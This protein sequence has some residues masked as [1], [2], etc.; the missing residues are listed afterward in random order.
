M[1]K[2][3]PLTALNKRALELLKKYEPARYNEYVR[4][5]RE[6][7][8]QSRVRQQ[9]LYHYKSVKYTKNLLVDLSRSLNIQEPVLGSNSNQLISDKIETYMVKGMPRE[10]IINAYQSEVQGFK[11]I[12]AEMRR[13]GKVGELK[14]SKYVYNILGNSMF[15]K[16]SS[17]FD[18]A[19]SSNRPF[20]TFE[21]AWSWLVNIYLG[22]TKTK[23]AITD[24]LKFNKLS[25]EDWTSTISKLKEEL[26]ARWETI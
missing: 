4:I 17:I 25:F 12:K 15:K 5:T 16:I 24:Y 26:R 3:N 18:S 10:H 6:K 9:Y 11:E 23:T 1:K 13:A 14:F 7:S 20:E 2:I 8:L 21:E 22:P 19:Q